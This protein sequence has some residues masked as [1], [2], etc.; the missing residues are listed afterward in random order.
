MLL[1]SD[2][3][4]LGDVDGREPVHVFALLPA[5][6]PEV[7]IAQRLCDRPHRAI[8]DRTM[9]HR[10]DGRDLYTCPAEEGLV[11]DVDLATV[12]VALDNRQA[13]FYEV[14]A[15]GRRRSAEAAREW[16]SAAAVVARFLPPTEPVR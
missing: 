3:M 13:K 10:G 9:L 5:H 4:R 12:D 8:S 14:T 1:R 11:S 7:E 6:D 15:A 2:P 16:R